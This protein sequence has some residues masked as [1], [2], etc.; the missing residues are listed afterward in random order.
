MKSSYIL[1]TFAA[2]ALL[3]L[4]GSGCAKRA[5][6][7]HSLR[8]ADQA[9]DAGNFEQAEAQ[10]QAI[11]ETDPDNARAVARLGLIY[12]DEGRFQMAAPY[13]FKGVTMDPSNLL[14]HVN[15][16]QIYLAIGKLKQAHEQAA[17]VLNS[18]AGDQQAPILLAQSATGAQVSSVTKQLQA[19]AANHDNPAAE[20]GLGL[21]ATRQDQVAAAL[22]DYERA[23]RLNRRFAPAYAALG[24]AYLQ[25]N[26]IEKAGNAFKAASDCATGTSPLQTAFGRFEIQTGNFA[27]AAIFFR[28]LTQKAPD[29]MPAWLGRA[30]VALDQKQFDDS[31]AALEEVLHRDPKNVD[32]LVLQARLEMARSDATKAIT[33]LDSLAKAYP[34]APRI[35]YELALACV[36]SQQKDRAINQ[37]QA[38]VDLDPDFAQASFLLAQLDVQKGDLNTGLALLKLLT[39]RHPDLVQAQLL[40]A[41]IYRLQN[42]LPDALALYQQLEKSLPKD[43][44]I[45]LLAGSTF[46]QQFNEDAAREEF[47]KTLELD[48]GNVSAQEE[49]AQLDLA[50]RNFTG[51]Q[52]RVQKLIAK[53]PHDAQPEIL[54]AK[55][56]LDQGQTNQA[57]T[58]LLKAADLPRGMQANLLLAQL[59]F[60]LKQDK[61]ALDR[62]DVALAKGPN[63]VPLLMFAATVQTDESDYR[64]AADT[65]E[66]LLMRNPQYSAALNNLAWLYSDHLGDLDKAYSLAQRARQLLPADPSTADT[67]GW[68]LYKQGQYASALGL[69]QEAASGLPQN[70]EVQY[71][72]GLDNYML[73]NE[74]SAR[75]GFQSAV[76]S[77][78]AFADRQACQEYLDILNIDP[79]I[80]DS[81]VRTRLEKRISDNPSDPVAFTRLAAVYQR[82]NETVKERDLCQTVLKANSKNVQAL[83][84]LARLCASD[85]PKK[86]F[87]LAKAAYQLKPNDPNICSTLGKLAFV[88]GNDSWAFSLLDEA[89]QEQPTNA[90]TLFDLANAVFCLGK[91]SEAQIDMQNAL[92]AGLPTQLSTEAQN[93]LVMVGV[94]QNPD[95]AEAN[96]SRIEGVLASNADSPPALFASAL[97]DAQ[98]SDP[99]GAE[100]AYE[101]LLAHHPNCTIACKNLAILYAENLTDPAKSYP[102]ALRARETFP[103]DPQV[104][105]AFAMIL[106]QQGD[107]TRA[108][109]LFDAISNSPEADARL[110]Y[111][112]GICEYHLKDYVQT[113]TSLEHALSLNLSGQE[114]ADAK[115][116]LA[117]LH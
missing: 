101:R 9:F 4:A 19:L 76:A 56:L 95:R 24:D 25:M 37:L 97:A 41:D 59:Y 63:D 13:L 64:A 110:F 94:C 61:N 70:P 7:T 43:P 58:A 10:Y 112:L 8:Q 84:T 66:K 15:L 57:E 33:E 69:L 102:I 32:A 77:D 113:K 75:Q 2:A 79:A 82:E 108:A 47:N 78:A 89:S 115:E 18:Y 35:H 53:D 88:N 111:C 116:T 83:V 50:D 74:D 114:A 48:P 45:P 44:E 86:A 42:D 106:F 103:D 6:S 49:L 46:V 28:G 90:R 81:S 17:F 38:T 21:L 54:L 96:Q 3:G 91:I 11:L 80:A 100:H 72:L 31:M 71:H 93:F 27:A 107:Y 73:D 29:Y 105:R 117:E 60:K 52:Q 85:D 109:D 16:G 67:L 92:Q 68:V 26:Q 62:I 87:D 5:Q 34:Q 36:M 98:N 65:Y 104:A 30:E 40:I 22:N 20:T 14:L 39:S 99:Y 55:I 1:T 12:F 51:A 23:L